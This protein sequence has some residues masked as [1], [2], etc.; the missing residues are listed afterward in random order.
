MN[1]NV[2]VPIVALSRPI[3]KYI[4]LIKCLQCSKHFTHIILEG[5]H[6]APADAGVPLWSPSST[7]DY[8][9]PR[10]FTEAETLAGGY[11]VC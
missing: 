10:D 8:H 6:N 5:F 9:D 3:A 4:A 2:A 11:P 1:T 7:S